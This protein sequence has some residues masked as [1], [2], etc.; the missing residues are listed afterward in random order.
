MA[1]D[2]TASTTV[3]DTPPVTTSTARFYEPGWKWRRVAVFA[4]LGSSLAL[5]WYLAIWSEDSAIDRDL[6]TTSGLLIVTT[7]GSYVFGAVWDSR[8]SMIHGRG[9]PR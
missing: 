3:T 1:D 5:L 7:L 8:N 2:P 4:T 9:D 6:A